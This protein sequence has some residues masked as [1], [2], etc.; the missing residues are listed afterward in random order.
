[1]LEYS[2]L[3][4]DW[5]VYVNLMMKREGETREVARLTSDGELLTVDPIVKGLQGCVKN[6]RFS[7]CCALV[8]NRDRFFG[9]CTGD[10]D[11][12]SRPVALKEAV[13]DMV[14]GLAQSCCD[15][16]ITAF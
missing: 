7:V 12:K 9:T 4:Y 13:S 1:V 14:Q 5:K 2:L 10:G 15:C 8:V 3:K 16:F 11:M 6:E